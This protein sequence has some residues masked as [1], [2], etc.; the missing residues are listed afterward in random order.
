MP[1]VHQS[2]S[3]FSLKTLPKLL[4]GSFVVSYVPLPE[5]Y[6]LG[7][8]GDC[9]FALAAPVLMLLATGL[10]F[11]IWWVL[12]VLMWPLGKFGALYGDR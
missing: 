3:R 10:V 5:S 8:G 1:T 12:L 6:Y 11:I 7:N 4:V 9:L 2:I